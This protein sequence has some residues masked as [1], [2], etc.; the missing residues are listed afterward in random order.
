MTGIRTPDWVKNAIFY[1]IF[2][3]RFARSDR[4]AHPPGITF[5]SWGT[6]PEEQGFQGG[7]LNGIA[8]KIGYLTDLGIDALYL[9]PIF[10]SASNHRY[11]TFDFMNVDP[12]LGGNDGLRR[13]LDT[14]HDHGVRI[15]LDGVFNHASR[16]FWPFHHV[17]ENGRS[18]PYVD[19]FIIHDWP[20]RPYSSDDKRPLN[21]EAWFNLPALP[22]INLANPGA[23]QYILDVA[24]YWLEFGIDG[25]RLD[26]ANEIDDEFWREFRQLVKSVNP[27]AYICGEIWFEAQRWLQGD[28]FD[29]VMNYIFTWNALSFFGAKTL[30]T[31]YQHP[32]L[33]LNPLDA[34]KFAENIRH[35]HGLYDWEINHAQLNLLDSHDMPRALWLLGEDKNAL[36]LCVL[37]MMTMPGA[38]CIYYGDEIGLSSPGDPHC[39]EA[40]PWHEEAKWDTDLRSFYRAAITLRKSYPVLATGTFQDFYSNE[41]IYAF[42]RSNTEQEA[43]VFFNT[44]D[45]EMMYKSESQGVILGRYKQVWPHGNVEIISNDEQQSI[46]LPAMDAIVL[47]KA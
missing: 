13:L 22:K 25:W 43:L 9:N 20:L 7:D 39:R 44:N 42:T 17:L 4:T 30:R 41:G 5:K 32:E 16:G 23:R 28:Q 12:L 47:I 1:Q 45:Q 34:S 18:S 21:Y 29:A 11:H 35:M 37:F 24:Q 27:E 8:D 6:P 2:P 10:S 38:P 33:H 15:V 46:R 19:W 3:D 14:A 26:V 40:F 36:R 31:D